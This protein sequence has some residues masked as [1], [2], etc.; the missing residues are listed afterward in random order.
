MKQ[1]VAVSSLRMMKPKLMHRQ[2]HT[3]FLPQEITFGSFCHLKTQI[4]QILR[5]LQ[6]LKLIAI[7]LKNK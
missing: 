7:I 3:C 4:L 6:L 5:M 2:L 1:M